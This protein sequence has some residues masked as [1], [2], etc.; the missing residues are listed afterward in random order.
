[1]DHW[2]EARRFG[3][4]RVRIEC[5]ENQTSGNRMASGFEF[6]EQVCRLSPVDFDA[7]D[8]S[9]E[10]GGKESRQESDEIASGRDLRAEDVDDHD[11][12]VLDHGGDVDAL[13][14]EV[15]REGKAQRSADEGTGASDH[16]GFG[17]EGPVEPAL[18]LADGESHADLA[19]A[20]DAAHQAGVPEDD[21]HDD[22]EDADHDAREVCHDAQ[23]F[24]VSVLVAE[25]EHEGR[26]FIEG[27]FLRVEC[28]SD[29]VGFFGPVGEV[30]EEAEDFAGG[31]FHVE[32]GSDIREIGDQGA[33]VDEGHAEV[34]RPG[35]GKI[36]RGD[37]PVHGTGDEGRRVA[38]SDIE[39][40]GE[41]FADEDFSPVSGQPSADQGVLQ[42]ENHHFF[43]GGIGCQEIDGQS[44]DGALSACFA[45]LVRD[46]QQAA[47]PNA[48][49]PDHSG[50]VRL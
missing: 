20:S 21:G 37:A 39:G 4:I 41:P 25:G 8:G 48:R 13:D 5:R 30:G 27:G 40:L 36:G 1:M 33:A 42:V 24:P 12:G 34:E 9:A 32:D 16:H 38:G 2:K 6:L 10:E 11:G 43:F 18:A 14:L 17:D 35:D 49:R 23:D 15:V 26:E 7:G 19:V 22:D 47:E 31:V 50:V 45:I 44:D 3:R 46:V 29:G 28:R